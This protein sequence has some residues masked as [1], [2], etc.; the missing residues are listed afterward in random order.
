V[1][2]H[3]ERVRSAVTT[4]TVVD[5][6][7]EYLSTTISVAKSSLAVTRRLMSTGMRSLGFPDD[8]TEMASGLVSGVLESMRGMYLVVSVVE[9]LALQPEEGD[10]RVSRNQSEP[11][12]IRKCS[13][14]GAT[15]TEEK[16]VAGPVANICGRCTRLAC[17]VL[18]IRFQE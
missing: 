14:C 6:Y 8:A 15:Q 12:G 4:G 3:L 17:G 7:G 16:I 2:Q 10:S 11:Q 18:G 1:T 5:Q 9:Q 13:F